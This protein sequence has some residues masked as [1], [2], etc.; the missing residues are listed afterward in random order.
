MATAEKKLHSAGSQID[1]VVPPDTADL[2]MSMRVE[3]AAGDPEWIEE[4]FRIDRKKL[5]EMLHTPGTGNGLT[6]EEFF[7]KVMDETGTQIKWPS[8]LK[9]GAKS[10]K[11]PHVKVEGVKTGVEEAKRRILQVLE[12]QA[13][14][15]TLKMDVAHTDHSHVIGKGGCNIRKV[16]EESGCHIHFPD[17]NRN[18]VN[19]EKSNQVSIAGPQP[20]VEVA[21]RKIRDL[22]PLALSFELPVSILPQVTPDTN[23]PLI[24]HIT[25]TFDVSVSVRQHANLYG[26]TC[27]VRG[28]QG[29]HA[30][31]QKATAI[32]IELLA[33][34]EVALNVSTQLDITSQQRLFL[35]GQNG[36]NLGNVMQVTHTQIVL[37]DLNCNPSRSTLLIRGPI[38]S[39]CLAKQLLLD[40]LPLCLMFDLE[41]NADV[42][43]NQLSHIM[44]SLGVS[45]GLKEKLKQPAKSVIVKALER[46]VQNMYEARRLVLGLQGKDTNKILVAPSTTTAR[47]SD[48]SPPES[49]GHPDLFS[50]NKAVSL[51]SKVEVTTPPGLPTSTRGSEEKQQETPSSKSDDTISARQ[52]P[53]I[54]QDGEGGSAEGYT[55]EIICEDKH[56]KDSVA[57]AKGK[58]SSQAENDKP[59]DPNGHPTA[60]RP[61]ITVCDEAKESHHHRTEQT[62]EPYRGASGDLEP[63]ADVTKSENYDYEKK[64]QLAA[65][66]MQ[67]RPVETEVRTPTDTWSGLGF[68]KS[69]PAEAFQE[70]RCAGRRT[71]KPYL[72]NSFQLQQI[73]KEKVTSG[74]DSDNWRERRRSTSSFCSP[75]FPVFGSSSLRSRPEQSSEPFFKCGSFPE[76]ISETASN[77]RFPIKQASNLTELFSQL[78]LGKYLD[79]FEQQEIDFQTFL[80]LTDEDLKEVGISTFGARRKMLLAISDLNKTKKKKLLEPPVVRPGYLEGGASGRLPWNVDMDVDIAALSNRW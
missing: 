5:E 38:E 48:L 40:C 30:G 14:K 11:D 23:S 51:E 8:K 64:R 44:R 56:K 74:S 15:V 37:Q 76:S 22:Q 16:M 36:S 63:S 28:L 78:G 3:T 80:T 69:M 34:A 21:R 24:R 10:K 57:M 18:N 50:S 70:L 73:S 25:Q 65:R 61:N 46:N 79:I 42:D 58:S 4:R 39:V 31:V 7:Q 60:S 67:N 33:S 41:T 62:S 12:A 45:I 59:P 72:S 32:L 47:L 26:G 13:S 75:S 54:G 6:G 9:I 43:P 53:D 35:L 52:I 29:N 19:M 20:G 27:T 66:A 77:C 1:Q 17:S 71:Y 55:S 49:A 2:T 68:S